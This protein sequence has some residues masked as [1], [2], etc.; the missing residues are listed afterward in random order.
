MGF[1]MALTVEVQRFPLDN[2]HWTN[3]LDDVFICRHY[4]LYS[5]AGWN[6]ARH[7][8]DSEAI[9]EPLIAPR[10]LPT[11]AHPATRAHYEEEHG[12]DAT[13]LTAQE[14]RQVTDQVRRDAGTCRP[15]NSACF[16]PDGLID[17]EALGLLLDH[18]DRAGWPARVVLWFD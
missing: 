1:D 5:R 3:Q 15:E 2:G 8:P 12:H 18:Y 14:W 4:G 11:N 13:W 6:G 17:A 10:G 9:K 16:P 7:Y